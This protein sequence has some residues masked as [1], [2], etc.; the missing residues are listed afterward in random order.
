MAKYVLITGCTKDS[1]GYF[2]AKS[3]AAYG[4]FVFA[5]AR[6][7]ESMEDLRTTSNVALMSLDVTDSKSIRRTHDEVQA[8]ANGRLDIL[9][10][11][12]GIVLSNMAIEATQQVFTHNS[13]ERTSNFLHR[14]RK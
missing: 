9:Y 14:F 13:A 2:L 4:Y 10:N 12:A 5:T 7:L 11:N 1:A 6:R 3:F 8:K